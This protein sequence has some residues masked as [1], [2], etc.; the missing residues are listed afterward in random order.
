MSSIET[1]PAV[2]E[3][4]QNFE[5]SSQIIATSAAFLAPSI[6][7]A[8]N[9]IIEAIQNDKKILCCGNGGSACDAQHF[10]AELLN[11]YERERPA[12]PA[13]SLTTDIAT[14]TAIA[15]D[16]AYQDIFAKQIYGLGQPGDV[17]FAITTSGESSN[18]LSAIKAAHEHDVTVIALTGKSGGQLANLL[19]ENDIEIRVPAQRTSR[20]Q[21]VHSVVIHCL[22]DMIDQR[23]F[24]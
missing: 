16:Y 4:L 3:I 12:L 11:R 1:T 22:C 17:L 6:D 14:I 5:Q 9:R 13:I 19:N 18:I 8:A 20:I 24:N 15:N 10:S 23:L 2:A 7:A 21:E